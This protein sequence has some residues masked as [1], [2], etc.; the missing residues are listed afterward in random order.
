MP[1]YLTPGVFVEEVSFR[2]K[3]IEDVSTT[4]T[5][6]ISATRTGPVHLE[7]DIVTS[8]GDFE[9]NYGDGDPLSFGEAS[10]PNFMWHAVR[11]FFTEGGKRLYVSRVFKPLDV[12]GEPPRRHEPI[13]PDLEMT[14]SRNIGTGQEVLYQDGLARAP[15]PLRTGV[16]LRAR[17]PGA[18][19]NWRVKATLKA[20]GNI[21][22]VR[23]DP[24]T[25][26]RCTS[27]GALHDRDLVWVRDIG[28]PFDDDALGRLYVARWDEKAAVWRFEAVPS[29]S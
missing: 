27:V 5:G 29:G 11:A 4:T 16:L 21:L 12:D 26:E 19:G 15:E 28:S 20:G 3:S 8:L 24:V 7:P 17:H 14:G 9:Q 22:G 18:A 1:E 13:D 10:I 23:T 25:R 6:F 2:A